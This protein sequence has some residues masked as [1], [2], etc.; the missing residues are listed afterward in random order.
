M[1]KHSCLNLAFAALAL[2]CPL[3]ALAQSLTLTEA[4][5]RLEAGNREIMAARA[6]L[7]LVGTGVTLAGA[8]PNPTLSASVSSIN[9]SRGIGGGRRGVTPTGKDSEEQH[10][11]PNVSAARGAGQGEVRGIAGVV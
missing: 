3:F 1:P 9:P 4:E 10:G 7:E 8:V 11:V 2:A 5:A 6:Q